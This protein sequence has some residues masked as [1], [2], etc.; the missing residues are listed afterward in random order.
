MYPH[1]FFAQ[2]EK[3]IHS[4]EQAAIFAR[5]DVNNFFQVHVDFAVDIQGG[6]SR[7]ALLTHGGGKIRFYLSQSTEAALS[8]GGADRHSQE[9]LFEAVNARK[10]ENL[11]NDENMSVFSL[12]YFLSN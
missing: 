4:Q 7:Q 1:R 5:E 8:C 2:Q 10:T 11:F 3:N 6:Q 12:T 9:D